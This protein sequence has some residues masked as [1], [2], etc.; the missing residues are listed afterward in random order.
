[1]NT[2]IKQGETEKHDMNYEN[3]MFQIKYYSCKLFFSY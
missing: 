1:M 3:L 2:Y